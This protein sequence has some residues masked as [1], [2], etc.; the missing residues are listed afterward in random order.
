[1]AYNCVKDGGVCDLESF[2][3][4]VSTVGP[5]TEVGDDGVKR[6]VRRPTY[7]KVDCN[8]VAIMYDCLETNGEPPNKPRDS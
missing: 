8:P 7:N 2:A 5:V 3:R 4:A 6:K 1:M